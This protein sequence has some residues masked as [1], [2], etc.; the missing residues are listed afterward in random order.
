MI[1]PGKG[2]PDY[3]RNGSDLGR[4]VAFSLGTSRDR[5]TECVPWVRISATVERNGHE[6][7]IGTVIPTVAKTSSVGRFGVALHK[8]RYG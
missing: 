4:V 6:C 7:L 5:S 1:E 2:T 8:R 3:E